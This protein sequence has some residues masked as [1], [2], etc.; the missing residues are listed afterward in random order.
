MTTLFTYTRDVVTGVPY[1]AVVADE[2]GAEY[3]W[4]R[5]VEPWFPDL[6]SRLEFI[7]FED[8]PDPTTAEGWLTLATR[9]LGSQV[10]VDPA[11]DDASNPKQAARLAQTYLNATLAEAD[12]QPPAGNPTLSGVSDAFDQVAQDYP[13]F[14][15][16]D[17]TL[18]DEDGAMENLVLMALGPID[19]EGP[20]GW[21]LRAMDGEPRE[22]DENEY[23]HFPGTMSPEPESEEAS[24]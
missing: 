21:I 11:Y 14:G 2:T 9:N 17:E 6:E 10:E 5:D 7:M 8:E 15:D 1:F 3:V 4:P 16:S 18:G 12:A 23:V 24:E 20:N 13:G 19:P 22:G